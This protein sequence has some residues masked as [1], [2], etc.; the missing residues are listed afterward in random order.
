[1]DVGD[2][3]TACA[4][5]G[6]YARLVRKLIV[7]SAASSRDLAL[8]PESMTP[9]DVGRTLEAL[10]RETRQAGTGAAVGE[11]DARN[12]ARHSAG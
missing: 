1:V 9:S 12:G 5:G 3:A 11:G 4:A 7:G 6:L 10:D 8:A 2:L